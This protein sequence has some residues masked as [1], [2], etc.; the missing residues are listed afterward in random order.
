M[1]S[2]IYSFCLGQTRHKWCIRAE[3]E[4]IRYYIYDM[5]QYSEYLVVSWNAKEG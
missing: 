1:Q 3:P 5:M 4:L 2:N